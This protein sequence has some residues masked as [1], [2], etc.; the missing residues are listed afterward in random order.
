MKFSRF[1]ESP[2]MYN[3]RGLFLGTN[4]NRKFKKIA[5]DV[6]NFILSDDFFLKH[7]VKKEGV[8]DMSTDEEKVF[9]C[10]QFVKKHI[11]YVSDKKSMGLAEFW[12]LPNE[13]LSLGTGDC[14]DGANLIVSLARNA[15]V[16]AHKLKVCAGWVV[17]GK[18]APLG[19]HAYPI[20]KASDG[21]WKVLDW[22]YYANNLPILKR[23][24]LHD[25]KYYRDIWFSFNDLHS[26][27]NKKK[28]LTIEET[29]K[30]TKKD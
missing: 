29:I 25:N 15:G 8:W 20:F 12:M 11:K 14:E 18:N 5:I 21:T 24:A 19:G 9:A 22:C 23:P 26:W 28:P 1:F 6:R 30:I 16:P 27:S 7:V 2:I 4:N 13:T 3:G 17:A 10:Q